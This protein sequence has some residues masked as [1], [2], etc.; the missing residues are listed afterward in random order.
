MCLSCKT[1]RQ[2][3]GDKEEEEDAAATAGELGTGDH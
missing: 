2:E 1:A 3:T